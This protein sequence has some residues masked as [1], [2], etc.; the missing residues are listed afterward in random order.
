MSALQRYLASVRDTPFEWGV[1]DCAMFSAKGTD[2]R[3]GT[4]FAARV[5]AIGV[6]S[7]VEYRRLQRTGATLEAMTI[8]ELGNPAEGQ[9]E[10][11][12][13]VLVRTA[14]GTAL[15]LAVPPV[16]LIA[17]NR[18]FVPVPLSAVERFWRVP[19]LK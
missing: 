7:A 2:A 13:V 6:R 3:C 5:A 10:D 9:I 18:G 16:A 1:H 15:G 8:A 11:G 4:S 19:C 12:D 17:A 14:I